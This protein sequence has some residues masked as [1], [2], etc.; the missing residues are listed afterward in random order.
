MAV[1][2]MDINLSAR[3]RMIFKYGF[4]HPGLY[5]PTPSKK[6]PVLRRVTRDKDHFL[7]SFFVSI[8]KFNIITG[9]P[10]YSN[11]SNSPSGP[12]NPITGYEAAVWPIHHERRSGA[13]FCGLLILN[14]CASIN[15]VSLRQM[16]RKTRS[17]P[18]G[19]N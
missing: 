9:S 4:P 6:Q 15:K 2:D 10:T 7:L 13:I 3:L 8:S 16:P 1:L 19:R 17:W 14:S 11:G 18:H 5:F 12:S